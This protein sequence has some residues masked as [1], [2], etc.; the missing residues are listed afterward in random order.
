[1]QHKDR[2]ELM[3]Y[4]EE[5]VPN[6]IDLD[7]KNKFIYLMS[8]EGEII[9]KVAKMVVSMTKTHKKHVQQVG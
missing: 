8:S 3:S 4:V 9:K 5:R 6:F 7:D 1:M 2:R